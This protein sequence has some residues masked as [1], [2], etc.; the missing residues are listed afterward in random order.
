MKYMFWIPPFIAG[1]L[2]IKTITNYTGGKMPSRGA[3]ALV[4]GDS[5]TEPS[6]GW[7]EA[8]AKKYRLGATAKLAKAG[9]KTDVMLSTL[10]LYLAS[11]KAPDYII[12]W[13]GAND[14]YEGVPQSTTLKN[15]QAM[16]DLARSKGSTFIIVKGYDPMK[17]SYNFDLSKM[18]RG[19]TQSGMIKARNEYVKLLSAYNQF[20]SDNV[21]IVP[22]YSGFSRADSTDG[23]HL[24]MDKYP[25]LG[26]WVGSQIFLKP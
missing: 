21:V 2:G 17:V 8:M 5:H 19:A 26:E 1:L 23:L 7:F 22:T 4:L 3:S 11:N 6:K 12:M 24:K 25:I 13:G 20:K 15:V 10:R 16:I 14:S 18:Y 9:R